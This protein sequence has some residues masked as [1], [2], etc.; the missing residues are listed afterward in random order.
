MH[1]LRL[2]VFSALFTALI[3]VGAYL[4][5][6]LGPVPLVLSNFF[7]ILAGLVLGPKWA[8]SAVALYLLLGVLGLPVFAGGGGLAYLAGP[9][10]GFLFAFFPSAVIVGVISHSG[11]SRPVKDI[12]ALTAGVLVLY[13]TGVPWLKYSLKMSWGE[14]LVLSMFP[15]LFG[16]VLKIA[17]AFAIK[18]SLQKGLPELFLLLKKQNA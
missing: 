2:S 3:A 9:T 5:I 17:A 13:V 10:G 14:S 15:Y 7:V 11:R 12:V 1:S 18:R 4:K 8:G 6:P 16:D